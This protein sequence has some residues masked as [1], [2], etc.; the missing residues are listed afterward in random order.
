MD[1][2]VCQEGVLGQDVRAVETQTVAL[3]GV[4]WPRDCVPDVC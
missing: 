3:D 1:H 4:R 2:S